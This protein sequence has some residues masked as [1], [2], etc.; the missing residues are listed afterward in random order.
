MGPTSTKSEEWLS[1]LR[2]LLQGFSLATTSVTSSNYTQHRSHGDVE[3]VKIIMFKNRAHVINAQ[4][5]KIRRLINEMYHAK[6]TF[7]PNKAAMYHFKRAF[8]PGKAVLGSELS[9][10]MP[11][12]KSLDDYHFREYLLNKT[13]ETVSSQQNISSCNQCH[14]FISS[15]NNNRNNTTNSSIS[16]MFLRAI[17]GDYVYEN[18]NLTG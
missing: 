10:H 1:T 13:N 16:R 2:E 7:P 9:A 11:S 4:E 12:T 8:P 17:L 3:K 18:A 6:S 5:K 15:N 14:P